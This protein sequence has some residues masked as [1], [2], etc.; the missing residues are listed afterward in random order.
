M[1]LEDDEEEEK[2]DEDEILNNEGY[3][4]VDGK[5]RQLYFKLDKKIYIFLKIKV[6]NI[7]KVCII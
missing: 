2:D 4:L 7:I 3:K 1:E 5:L 6:I